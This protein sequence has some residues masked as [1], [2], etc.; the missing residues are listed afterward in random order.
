M[1]IDRKKQ[2]SKSNTPDELGKI[3]FNI[4]LQGLNK[5]SVRLFNLI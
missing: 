2:K 3:Y 1:T 4:M 5:L